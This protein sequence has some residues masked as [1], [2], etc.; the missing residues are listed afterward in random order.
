MGIIY[1]TTNL[2]NG[3]IY[4]GQHCTSAD[5]GYLGSGRLIT[6]AINEIGKENFKREILEFCV[7][8]INQRETYWIDALSARDPN[9]GYNIIRHGGGVGI[10]CYNTKIF[11]PCDYCNNLFEKYKKKIHVTNFC[12]VQ[13]Y[14]NWE[15]EHLMAFL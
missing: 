15:S 1:K 4:V 10:N 12:C 3:L 14:I 5:D 11:I 7:S 2:I 8:G 13:C 9:I 6:S